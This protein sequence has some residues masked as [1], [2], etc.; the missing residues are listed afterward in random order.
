M[1]KT[2]NAR[3]LVQRH[4]RNRRRGLRWH[5][6]PPAP[7]SGGGIMCSRSSRRHASQPE[8]QPNRC[9]ARCSAARHDRYASV[10]SALGLAMSSLRNPMATPSARKR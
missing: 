8:A 6:R 1:E 3:H 9:R 2:F 5:V 10:I 7:A 4:I